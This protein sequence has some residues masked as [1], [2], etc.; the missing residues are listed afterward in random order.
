MV[1]D[2]GD[3]AAILAAWENMRGEALSHWQS[4]DLIREVTETWT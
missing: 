2:P 1:S 3:I 4:L